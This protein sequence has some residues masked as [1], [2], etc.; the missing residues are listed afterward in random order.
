MRILITEDEAV[1][2]MDLMHLLRELGHQVTGVAV[3]AEE[4]YKAIKN[5]KPDLIL[6]DVSLKGSVNGIEAA[7]IINQTDQ[8]PVIFVTGQSDRL[9]LNLIKQTNFPYI[10]KP[11]D[12]YS[13][14]KNIEVFEKI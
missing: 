7:K 2:A 6:M 3:S 12:N 13:L 8:I 14:R 10:V 9:T 5:D 1:I 4:A 11:F